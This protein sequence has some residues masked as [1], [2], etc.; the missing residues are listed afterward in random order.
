MTGLIGKTA[1]IAGGATGIGRAA[2]RR[3]IEEGAVVFI[4]VRR[5]GALDAA[6]A[7]EPFSESRC[8]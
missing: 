6:V 1:V 5:R 8:W 2:A 7:P 4:F 3:V